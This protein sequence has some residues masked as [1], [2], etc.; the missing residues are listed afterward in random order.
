MF[1]RHVTNE[2]SAYLHGELPP[3]RRGEVAAHLRECAGCRKEYEEIR[4]GASFAEAMTVTE[5]PDSLW[6]GIE[7]KL[8]GAGNP[9]PRPAAGLN[10]WSHLPTPVRW[11]IPLAAALLVAFGVGRLL[12]KSVSG[13]E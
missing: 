1:A 6:E 11:A 8:A 9:E 10:W 3:D 4:L 7:A 12:N 13:W 5:A 2:L